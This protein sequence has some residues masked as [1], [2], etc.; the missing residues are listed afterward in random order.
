MKNIIISFVFAITVHHTCSQSMRDT[1]KILDSLTRIGRFSGEVLVADQGRIKWEQS[2]GLSNLETSTLI[3]HQTIFESASI[4]KQFIALSV[5]QL[6]DKGLLS[7]EDH[8]DKFFAM[9]CLKGIC[10][11]HLLSHTS[12]LTDYE[13]LINEHRDISKIHFNQD[14]I[15]IFSALSPPLDFLPGEKNGI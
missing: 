10:I 14:V 8:L 3:N 2:F 1:E 11:K 9:P 6:R 15:S 13:K 7:L 4:T 5:L 12:G